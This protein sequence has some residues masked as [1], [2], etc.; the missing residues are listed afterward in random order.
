MNNV[1]I[2]LVE[3]DIENKTLVENC[4]KEKGYQVDA[5][6]DGALAWEFLQQ[7]TAQVDAVIIAKTLPGISGME[8]LAKIQKHPVLHDV[9]VLIQTV[10]AEEGKYENALKEG[11]QFYLLKPLE[12]KKVV[13]LVKAALRTHQRISHSDSF[14]ERVGRKSSEVV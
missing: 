11:A 7:H 3:D 4:L 9:P 2:V 13:S 6:E 8:L 12:P 5:F 14:A 10:D 1:H